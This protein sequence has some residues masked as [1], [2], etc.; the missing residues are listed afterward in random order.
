MQNPSPP[1]AGV[2]L[3][4]GAS[5]RMG[6]NKLLLD[7]N[8]ATLLR[9]VATRALEAGLDPVVVVLGHDAEPAR[10]QLD[11][12]RVRIEVSAGYREGIAA[13]LRAGIAA[14]AVD[15]PAAVVL[16][17]DMPL[18]TSD[19]IRTVASC[20]KER[21]ARIVVSDYEGIIAPP[22]LYDRAFFP[23]LASLTGENAGREVVRRH[24]DEVKAVRWPRAMLQ[25][26]DLPA[27][28]ERLR[29][30]P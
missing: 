11:G 27:D 26:L 9:R 28:Y 25:D 1:A 21:T 19:M 5:T 24:S 30:G 13:S 29:P 20:Y 17:A 6:T 14:L 7:L 15:T 12:L 22:V 18:V 8:G 16:L 10:Q 23:E 4:A 3:A 2:V